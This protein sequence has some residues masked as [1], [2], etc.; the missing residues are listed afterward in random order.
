[1]EAGLG[2]TEQAAE[3]VELPFRSDE[4]HEPGDDTPGDQDAGEPEPRAPAFGDQ[5]AGDLED[6]LAGEEDAGTQAEDRGGES[7]VL[8][9]G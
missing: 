3:E 4:G 8:V 2:G 5:G 6:H 1:M 7:E 9:H